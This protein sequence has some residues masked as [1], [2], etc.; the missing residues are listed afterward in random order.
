[1]K[2]LYAIF[3]KELSM[4]ST[5]E[6]KHYTYS[7]D[8]AEDIAGPDEKIRKVITDDRLTIW[9]E[10]DLYCVIDDTFG[11][12]EF[13]TFETADELLEAFDLNEDDIDFNDIWYN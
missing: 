3:E 7:Y 8:E 1:M 2:T 12:Y 9:Y 5:P 4:D 6:V 11:C 10:D 13:Y